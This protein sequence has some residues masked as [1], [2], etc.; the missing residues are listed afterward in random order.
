MLDDVACLGWEPEAGSDAGRR[1][2]TA[3]RCTLQGW[4]W[5]PA[6]EVEGLALGDCT[7]PHPWCHHGGI[8]DQAE[9]LAQ[10][11]GH[12]SKNLEALARLPASSELMWAAA[13]LAEEAR[14]LAFDGVKLIETFELGR[15]GR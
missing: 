2:S 7:S 13:L 4:V 14:E 1:D 11:F 9:A 5:Q 15:G 3:R 10:R 6:R 12:H 8:R